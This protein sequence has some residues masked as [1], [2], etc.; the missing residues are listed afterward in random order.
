[1]PSSLPPP[2]VL[3]VLRDQWPR[4]LL[5]A[6]LREAG[7]DAAGTRTLDGAVHLARPEPGRGAVAAIVLGHEALTQ[8]DG[9]ALERLRRFTPAPILLVAPAG[10]TI[11][12]GPWARV[13]RRPVSVGE[14]AGA[15]A[16]L[17]PL[18][19]ADRHPID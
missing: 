2:R 11:E 12:D 16:S 6:A 18:P 10:R 14:L 9:P 8:P 5:R 19:P 1:M 17:A 3:L 7:Y 15:V 4:A 13:L